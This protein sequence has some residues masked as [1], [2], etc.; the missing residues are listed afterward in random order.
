MDIGAHLSSQRML[1]SGNAAMKF[2]W[3]VAR[4]ILQ[5]IEDSPQ[6]PRNF[7]FSALALEPEMLVP[8]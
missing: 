4:E 2:E 1:S 3:D 7:Y 5:T 6:S 8:G